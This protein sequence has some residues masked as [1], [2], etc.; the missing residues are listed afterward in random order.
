MGSVTLRNIDR[1]TQCYG[2]PAKAGS[3]TLRGGLYMYIYNPNVTPL[4]RFPVSDRWKE[5]EIEEG[6]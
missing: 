4:P 2:P 1:N 3:V 5:V 6:N